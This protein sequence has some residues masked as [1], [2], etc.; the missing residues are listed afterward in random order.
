ML[1]I[2]GEHGNKK[3]VGLWDRLHRKQDR[4][5][6]A[7]GRPGLKF[8]DGLLI[9]LDGAKALSAAVR[10]VFGAKALIQRRYCR[11]TT[12]AIKCFRN[13][14]NP[15]LAMLD[16]LAK[17]SSLAPRSRRLVRRY[18]EIGDP[19][20]L[21]LRTH[22]CAGLPPVCVDAHRGLAL[23]A[24]ASRVSRF[25]GSSSCSV[26]IDG[27]KTLRRSFLARLFR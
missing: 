26:T 4:G 1:M 12:G 10:E 8:E 2:D 14:P 5:A 24:L 16:S 23:R 19:A 11:P 6:R 13:S 20:G 18:P 25:P 15:A 9:V 7:T 17:G 21:E 3:P 22:G 27:Q